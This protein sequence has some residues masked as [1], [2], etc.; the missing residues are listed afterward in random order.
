MVLKPRK[1]RGFFAGVLDAWK[2]RWYIR[3]R[4]G[5]SVAPC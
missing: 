1:L 5:F 3:P 4:N 2:I